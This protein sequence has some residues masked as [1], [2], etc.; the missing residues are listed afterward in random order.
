M[1]SAS[2]ASA[3]RRCLFHSARGARSERRDE[4][5]R[6]TNDLPT[7]QAARH[8]RARTERHAPGGRPRRGPTTSAIPRRAT[9]RQRAAGRRRNGGHGG[10]SCSGLF[11]L[12]SLF[13]LPCNLGRAYC[14]DVGSDYRYDRRRFSSQHH[15]FYFNGLSE[16]G[17]LGSRINYTPLGDTTTRYDARK[18]E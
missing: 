9:S 12:S 16:V 7:A 1:G 14:Y 13:A 3:S 15:L 10:S 8:R 6:A 5:P 17:F 18:K 4:Q 2:V 11:P